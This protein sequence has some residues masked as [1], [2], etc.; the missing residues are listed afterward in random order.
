MT[1]SFGEKTAHF[2]ISKFI[3]EKKI[4]KQ[5]FLEQYM[6]HANDRVGHEN[7][8]KMQTSLGKILE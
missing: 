3:R 5:N 6:L 1:E 2:W 8:K 4:N 7:G